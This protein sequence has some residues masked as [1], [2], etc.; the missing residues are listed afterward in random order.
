MHAASGLARRRRD[1]GRAARR[2]RH[3]ARATARHAGRRHPLLHHAEPQQALDHARY[4]VPKRAKRCSSAGQDLRR[5]RREFRSGRARPHGFRLGAHSGAQPAHDLWRR[6]KALGPVLTRTARSTRTSRSAPAAQP[7]RPASTMVLRW[8][9][10]RRSATPAPAC[11]SHSASWRRSTTASGP[12]SG[13]RVL[14]PMQ[15]GVL[16]LCRVKL[17]DQQRLAHGPLE[18]FSSTAKASFGD[19]VPR[20]GNDSG[21]GQPGWILKCKGWETRSRTPT[22][23]SSPRRRCGTDLRRDRQAGMENRSGLCHAAGPAADA[24][25]DLRAHRGVDHDQE[26]VRGHGRSCNQLDIPCGP[27]CR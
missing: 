1:Q 14:A 3:H 12:A 7:R 11:I 15:D 13:Q 5:A 19:A 20:A 24:R 16:N 26:Q 9:P 27:S 23:I 10:A 4:Q 17:R 2:R 6:S 25:T 18:E 21:G 22:S 8:S